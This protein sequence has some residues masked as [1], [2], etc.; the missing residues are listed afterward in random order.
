MTVLALDLGGS[1]VGCGVVQGGTVLASSFIPVEANSLR[2][3]LPTLAGQLRQNCRNA[4]VLLGGCKGVGVGFPAIVDRRTNEI[5]STLGDKF[6]DVTGADLE[7]WAAREFGLPL[8]LEN[9]AKLSLLGEQVAGGAQGFDDV[10][11]VTLGT[12]VGV[13]AMLQKRLL[14]SRMGQ[15]GCVGGHLIVRLNGRPCI[16]GANGCAEA[17]ASTSVLPALCRDWPG[18]AQS[19]L[20]QVDKVNFAT[21]Y[22]ARDAGDPVAVQVIDHCVSIWSALAVNLVHAYG[23]QLILFGGGVA[24][25]GERLLTPIRAY[26]H[27]HTWKTTRGEAIVQNAKLGAYAAL[28]G[29]EVLFAEEFV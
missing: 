18:F 27:Q 23:P 3:I 22:E 5:L 9:D 10:V 24:Q 12:G 29:A 21:L 17:E 6:A 20:A 16:C 4:S 28:I 11:M 8:R 2:Q 13:A 7:A 25:R 15:G 1:H 26:V 19:T 14:H